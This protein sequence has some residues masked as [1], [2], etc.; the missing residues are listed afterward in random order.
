MPS[1]RAMNRPPWREAETK[2]AL[3]FVENKAFAAARPEGVDGGLGYSVSLRKAVEAALP[4]V[5]SS[6]KNQPLIEARLRMTLGKSF[7]D[8]GEA[9]IA[10]QQ[11]EAARAIY[12]K[13]RGPE[14]PDTLTAMHSLADSYGDIG[15]NADALKLQE[16]TLALRKTNLGPQHPDTLASMRGLANCL[17]SL[18][19]YT[20]AIKLYEETLALQKTN[21]GPDHPDTLRTMLFLARNSMVCS[22]SGWSRPSLVFRRASVSS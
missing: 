3:D 9:K 14:H 19:R 15:Q 16:A 4:F 13:H 8:L 2:S 10:S 1:P 20:D 12:T 6:F 22:V 11:F 17:Y 21:L 7:E 18:G 5:A